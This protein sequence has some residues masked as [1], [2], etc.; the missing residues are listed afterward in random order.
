MKL[1][2]RLAEVANRIMPESVVV[3]IGTDHAYLPVYLIMEGICRKV[4]GVEKL[5]GSLEKAQKTVDLFNL[6]SRIELRRGD[7]FSAIRSDE[8]V[9]VAVIAGLGGR[10][11]C[12]IL[13]K[14]A[15]KLDAIGYLVLQPMT[16]VYLLRRW[17]AAHGFCI[18][19][20]SL[21][22][23]KKRFYEIMVVGKGRQV[24]PEYFLSEVGPGLIESKD[25]LLVPYLED[26]ISRC[27]KIINA[28]S[29]AKEAAASRKLSYYKGKE[30]RLKE[31]LSLVVATSGSD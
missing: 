5:A 25:P 27:E 12:K 31:V 24:Q 20:E 23:E 7:G 11:I 8:Q 29:T 14:G 19:N 18:R 2:P 15:G 1:K 3:D 16:D 9:D 28:L 26:K 21:A 17:L 30:M 13:Q 4:I 10:T 22:R 6:A